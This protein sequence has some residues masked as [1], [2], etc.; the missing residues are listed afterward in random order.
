MSR[1][2]ARFHIKLR[3]NPPDKSCRMTFGREHPAQ[4]EQVAGLHCFHVR[5]EWLGWRREVDTQFFQARLSAGRRNAFAGCHLRC[6]PWMPGK[7]DTELTHS[8]L[9]SRLRLPPDSL[10]L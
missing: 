4:K 3:S 6:P 7:S 8:S 5:A 9:A 1:F 10:S 2:A